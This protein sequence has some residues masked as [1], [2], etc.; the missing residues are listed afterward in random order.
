L[1]LLALGPFFAFLN[2]L[3]AFAIL[4]AVEVVVVVVVVVEFTMVEFIAL[5]FENIVQLV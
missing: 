3:P 1:L 5:E 4:P 2:R